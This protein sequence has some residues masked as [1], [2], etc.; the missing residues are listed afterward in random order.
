MQGR[1]PVHFSKFLF[2]SFSFS[3]RTF[4]WYQVLFE[5]AFIRRVT[6][7][8]YAA[9]VTFAC[10]SFVR[11]RLIDNLRTSYTTVVVSTQVWV[12]TYLTGVAHSHSQVAD[13]PPHQVWFCTESDS[14][15]IRPTYM[16]ELRLVLILPA[17]PRVYRHLKRF[18]F[19]PRLLFYL[20]FVQCISLVF[21]IIKSYFACLFLSWLTSTYE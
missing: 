19:V 7:I 14:Q 15:G 21:F 5:P 10:V 3:P 8:G 4:T 17:V 12:D 9:L 16:H 11:Q 20:F 1:Y 6:G 2:F 18:W 13:L